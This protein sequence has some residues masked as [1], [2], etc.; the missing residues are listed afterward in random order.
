MWSLGIS[1]SNRNTKLEYTA[2]DHL[3]LK[4]A[5]DIFLK[6]TTRPSLKKTNKQKNKDE[7]ELNCKNATH[8]KWYKTTF[9]SFHWTRN[10]RE[11]IQ[12]FT[13]VN[14]GSVWSSWI[15]RTARPLKQTG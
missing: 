15:G 9:Y 2:N 14:L 7:K 5:T 6:S 12:Q 1:T 8:A 3:Y 10:F 11:S 13:H 4:E